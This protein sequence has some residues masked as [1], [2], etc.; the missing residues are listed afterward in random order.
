MWILQLCHSAGIEAVKASINFF[1]RRVIS[2]TGLSLRVETVEQELIFFAW[3]PEYLFFFFNAQIF[4]IF[5]EPYGAMIKLF[6][7]LSINSFSKRIG[8]SGVLHLFVYSC[9]D[10]NSICMTEWHCSRS[11]EVRSVALDLK[12][13]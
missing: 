3:S 1:P 7:S 13:T 2:K 12:R 5:P 6:Q 9:K 8:L 10:Q 11:I 4:S